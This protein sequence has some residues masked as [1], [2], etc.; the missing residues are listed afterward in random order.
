MTPRTWLRLVVLSGLLVVLGL[1][2][3]AWTRAPAPKAKKPPREIT[4]SIGMKLVLIPAGK[5]LMG[6]PKGERG[7]DTDEE[8]HQVEITK[9]FYLGIYEVTQGQFKEVMGKNPSYFS[10]GG[11]GKDKVK[12]LNTDDFPVE[13]VSW[14]EAQ[15][16]L[17]KLSA[18]REESKQGRRYRLPTEAEW[19]WSC[20][21]GPTEYQTFHCGN[22]LS[23]KQANIN[24]WA[25]REP[26]LARTCQVGSYKPNAFG[27]YDMHGNVWEWCSDWYDLDFYRTSPLKDPA[28]PS[29]GTGRVMRGGGWNRDGQFCRSALRVGRG[30]ASVTSILGFRA[31]LV[32]ASE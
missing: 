32:L 5:F 16:F 14:Q 18:L 24:G 29:K 6:S 30:P 26:F 2:V 8:Q 3:P 11:D 13:T 19:E 10:T 21:G 25:D 12:G 17:K 27:R 31:A 20:R 28:G 22:S 9:P 23:S 15:T 7:R 4:N 1:I